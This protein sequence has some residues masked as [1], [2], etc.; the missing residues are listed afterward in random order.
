MADKTAIIIGASRGLGAGLAR[1]LAGRGWQVTATSRGPALDLDTAIEKSNGRITHAEV[2]IDHD[3]SIEKLADSVAGQRFDLV[4]INAGVIGPEHADP[5]Q[6]TTIEMGALM[7]TNAIA[8]IRVATALLPNLAESGTLAF[9]S[10]VLGSVGDNTGGGYDLYRASK[11]ALNTLTRSLYATK[12]KALG[13]KVLTLHPGWVRTAMGGPNA[14]LSVDESVAG[15]ADVIEAA[16]PGHRYLDYIGA[17]I[18][19]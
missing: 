18:P 2:D 3:G 17:E 13:L 15:L 8:P 7:H 14:T 6:V 10:S 4:F 9:M 12:L 5:L 19:W 1:E 16:T 11:A